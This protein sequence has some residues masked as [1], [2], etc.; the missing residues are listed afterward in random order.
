MLFSATTHAWKNLICTYEDGVSPIQSLSSPG[1][2]FSI[3]HQSVLQPPNPLPSP[4]RLINPFHITICAWHALHFKIRFK[5]HCLLVNTGIQQQYSAAVTLL[6]FLFLEQR[7]FKTALKTL[8]S[9][10][11]NAHSSP[12]AIKPVNSPQRPPLLPPLRTV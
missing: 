5:L 4:Q 11:V 3:R 1:V 7:F 9:C 8:T 2:P 6:C 12:R 10:T